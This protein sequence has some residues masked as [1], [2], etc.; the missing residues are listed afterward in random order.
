VIKLSQEEFDIL[1]IN[2]HILTVDK[3]MNTIQRGF[4]LINNTKIVDLGSMDKF[5]SAYGNKLDVKEEIDALGDLILPGFIN[6]HSHFAMTLFRGLADDLPLMEWLNSYIWPIEAKL[7]P[8]DCFIGTQ[9][10]AIEMIQG[11]TTSACDMYFYEEK[12][13]DALEAIG[14]R[15]ILGYGMIDLNKQEKR[16][17]EVKKTLK[18]LDYVNK[19]SKVCS[20]IISPHAPNTCSDELL[21]EAK[22]LS[23]KHNLPLQIHLSETESEVKDV[24]KNKK[25]SPV[26]YL[27]KLDFLS[28]KLVA[29]HCVWLTDEE[30]KILQKYHVNIAHNPTS[31]LKLGSGL[32]R[33]AE[34]SKLGVNIALGTDGA[35]SNNNLSMLQEI[36]MASCLHKGIN[37]NPEL[38]PSQD[39][40]K[41]ATING[42]KSFGLESTIGSLEIGK[43]ADLIIIDT[44][45]PN[46]WPPHNPY[47]LIAYSAYDTNVKTT[48]IDGKIVM[49]NRLFLG[50]DVNSVLIKA[51]DSITSLLDQNNLKQFK[52]KQKYLQ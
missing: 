39:A 18:F 28:N 8:E 26:E 33:Y 49:R 44:K 29:A 38:L 9:L 24:K 40:L 47:S 19:N 5:H 6:A 32:F 31:N 3:D 10:A 34:L 4:V 30:C 41:M 43:K 27:E 21:L 37:L 51:K 36:R 16:E 12:S 22:Q 48:I 14:F 13:L 7:K 45:T 25:Y 17:I 46:V 15:G 1:I 50:I 2:A 20:A 42:A 35:A 11:G 23:E 52:E